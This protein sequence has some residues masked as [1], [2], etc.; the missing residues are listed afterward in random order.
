MICHALKGCYKS[1]PVES[2][3]HFLTL[4]C[5][6]ERNAQ[7]ANLVKRAEDGPWSSVHVRLYGNEEQKKLLSPWP[8]PEPAYYRQWLNQSQPREEMERIR[9]AISRSKPYGSEK[10][11]GRTV[12]DFRLES[13]LRNPP[14]PVSPPYLPT[15]SGYILK[16]QFMVIGDG[17]TFCSRSPCKP[18]VPPGH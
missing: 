11:V 8:V 18:Y 6:V 9:K 15:V 3:G 12:A 1:L 14:D 16:D 4:V 2:G 17:T 7:R 5:H 10:W 13:T